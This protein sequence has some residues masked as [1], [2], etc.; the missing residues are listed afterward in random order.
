MVGFNRL[1]HRAAGCW[2]LCVLACFLPTD[3]T[4]LGAPRKTTSE[5]SPSEP[6]A[7]AKVSFS[8]IAEE[9]A[10]DLRG[11][12]KRE[13]EAGGYSVR[14][15]QDT[16]LLASDDQ[17]LLTCTTMACNE[18]LAQLLGVQLVVEGEVKRLELS[19]FSIRLIIRDLSSGKTTSPMVEHCN[20]CSTD[21]VRQAVERTARRLTKNAP[22]HEAQWSHPQ[23]AENAVLVI[24]SEPAGAAV[25]IDGVRKSE[26]T[27]ATFLLSAGVH[28]LLLEDEHQLQHQQTVEVRPGVTPVTVHL[29]LSRPT[30]LRGLFLASGVVASVL[31]AGAIAGGAY[32]LHIDGQ[33]IYDEVCPN[34]GLVGRRCPTM[35]GNLAPAVTLFVGAGVLAAGSGVLLYFGSRKNKPQT[36]FA[37]P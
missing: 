12:I 14:K 30:S 13:L 19:T 20:V 26:R 34:E 18:R 32:L 29:R 6:I 37:K 3:R 35:Y 4:A 15:K 28:N 23:A 21:D 17:R 10:A 9:L 5:P 1:L 33:P 7:I 16:D 25:S 31:G 24:E 2:L 11:I 22:S 36:V 8:G 27:P